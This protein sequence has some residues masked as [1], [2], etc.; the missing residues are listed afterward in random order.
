METSAKPAPNLLYQ[1]AVL[2]S[3]VA[4]LPVLAIFPIITLI[5]TPLTDVISA[6]FFGAV[7]FA[8]TL[9]AVLAG[10]PRISVLESDGQKTLFVGRA[11]VAAQHLGVVQV[12]SFKEARYERGPK[13]DA[14]AFTSFQPSAKYML[15]VFLNDPNDPTPYWLFSTRNPRKLV[16]LLK[17]EENRR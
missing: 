13:L 3:I 1:E 11:K 15:K 9:V 10:S 2:P 16:D 17:K 5:L 12:I 8:V 6:V 14:R 4:T 7:G